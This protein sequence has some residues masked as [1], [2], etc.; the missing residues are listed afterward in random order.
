MKAL[1]R[2][3]L[4]DLWSTKTQVL[5][6]A[7]VIAC[8]IGGSI[9]SFST[10]ESLLLAR[11]HYYQAASFPH[12]FAEAKRAPSTLVREIAAIPGVS[13]AEAR[14]VRDIQLD[15]ASVDQPITAR[16]I[17]LPL[18]RP[19]AMNRLSLR[20]GR[21]PAPGARGEVLVNE[22][23]ADVR[24]IKAGDRV[25]VLLN[26]KRE[27]LVIAG[28]ALSPEYIFATRGGALPDDEWFAV[29]WMDAERLAAAFNMEGAFNSVLIRLEHGAS[30]SRVAD[31][32]DALLEP[33]GTR[34]AYGR[35]EHISHKI[36]SQ[37]IN[38]QRVFGTVIPS[39]FMLVAAFILNVVLHRQV[40]AQRGEIA[41]LKALGY[42]NTSI[43]GHYLAYTSV[44]AGIGMLIG[45][46]V[47]DRLGTGLTEL[48]VR[49]FHFPDFVY[50]NVGWV[51]VVSGALALAAAYGGALS[52]VVGVV[53]L[54][55][56]EALRPPAPAQFRPLLVE[57]LGVPQLL[58]A[59]TRMIFRNLER[60]PVRALL[61]VTGIAGSIAIVI[62]GAF[63]QDALDRFIDV[64]F[65]AAQPANVYIGFSD[66]RPLTVASELSRLPAVQEVEMIRTIGA[67]IR[68]G[69]RSYRTAVTG[70]VDDAHLQR[71]VDAQLA[72]TAPAQGAV[73][74]T[75]R[76]ARRLD[77]VRGD[78]ISVE[79]ME[80]PRNVAQLRV[81]A[82]ARELTGMNAWMRLDDLNR[83][84][85]EGAL[86]SGAGLQIDRTQEKLLLREIKG[87]PM[88]AT[89]I[90]K[91]TLLDT[92]R[93]TTARNLLF[94]TTVLTVFAVIIAVGVVYNNA[95]I[96]LAER[97][98]ELASLRV[99]GFTRGEVSLL[100]LGELALEIAAAIPL[101]LIAGYWLAWLILALTHGET[102]EIPLV[103]LPSTY[104]NAAGAIIA[105]GVVSALIVRA[106][107]DR[108]DL[109]AVLKTRE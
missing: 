89:V 46:I 66:P 23:F 61:T 106:R 56:A 40:N 30:A 24:G 51:V 90:V 71:I 22:R 99:L 84:A 83:L 59:S 49:V 60:R 67:R 97:A 88:V 103:I 85:G 72:V 65:R 16:V 82:T 17:G 91:S 35:D 2:K 42:D 76:L 87:I 81:A 8:G 32:L 34:G 6:I 101:G 75:E 47:G 62:S 41:A 77:V 14:V 109:V 78:W 43:A 21:W 68:A 86:A 93:A 63:W 31:A 27:Q 18:D 28:T 36:V 64:Q 50:S 44:V 20:S 39:V 33:Y 52:A 104:V 26:G 29:L 94:F 58:P 70:I 79:L 55:P 1:N 11:E 13:Q 107:I 54:R 74:L 5:S 69:H 15:L 92:F 96:Q 9:A 80:G 25:H 4:R 73:V 10:H 48:Y 38:Q 19:Q 7:L 102:F 95:R 37:E 12:L 45:M 57:R 98:W 100:L 53:R 3:L 108:L 105:A